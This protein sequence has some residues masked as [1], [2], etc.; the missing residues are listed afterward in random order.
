MS[1]ISE[2]HITPEDSYGDKRK[3]HYKFKVVH[4]GHIYRDENV[5]KLRF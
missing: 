2:K 4:K 1:T 5:V 3:G